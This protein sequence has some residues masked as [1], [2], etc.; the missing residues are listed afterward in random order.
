MVFYKSSAQHRA[1][2]EA[3]WRGEPALELANAEAAVASDYTKRQHVFRLKLDDGCDY[4]F[5]VS[6][7][8]RV[9]NDISHFLQYVNISTSISKYLEYLRAPGA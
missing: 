9:V 7:Y 6:T 1:A 5:Q 2:P 4:L 8:L 3:T